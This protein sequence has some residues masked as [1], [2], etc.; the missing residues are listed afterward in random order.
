M[1]CV[2][3]RDKMGFRCYLK[4][5]RISPVAAT[6]EHDTAHQDRPRRAL[7]AWLW[8]PW[9]AK[10]WWTAIPVWWTGLAASNV[11]EFLADFYSSALAGFLNVL[12]MPM[13]ALVVLGA[14]YVRDWM[15]S[16]VGHGEGR[17][18]SD[19]EEEEE[20]LAQQSWEEHH[21]LMRDM[22]KGTDMFDPRSGALWIG[23]PLNPSNPGYIDPHRH[24]HS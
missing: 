3:E 10:L 4:S 15:D 11:S 20:F 23:N 2:F 6:I 21:R 14:G 16:V 8:K 12:F 18:L 13:T 17:P 24:H 5:E 9:Y 1:S 19:E 7:S 22:G